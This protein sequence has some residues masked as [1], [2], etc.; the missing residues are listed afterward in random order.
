MMKTHLDLNPTSPVPSPN[1]LEDSIRD[2]RPRRYML[3]G[4]PL[5]KKGS[6]NSCVELLPSAHILGFNYPKWGLGPKVAVKEAYQ[7]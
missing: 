5:G 1:K 3:I 4:L 6:P 7:M 2:D